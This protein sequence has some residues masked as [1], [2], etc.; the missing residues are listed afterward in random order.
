M[1]KK[2]LGRLELH[3]RYTVWEKSV[4]GDEPDPTLITNSQLRA[5]LR[6]EQNLYN[7]RDSCMGRVFNA[8]IA[9]RHNT[10]ILKQ[11]SKHEN[12]FFFH[13]AFYMRKFKSVKII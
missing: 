12:L 5:D 1:A 3:R 10:Q 7:S 9:K 2:R 8:W 4:L 6:W 11:L 13:E